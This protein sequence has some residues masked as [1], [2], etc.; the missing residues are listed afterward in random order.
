MKQDIHPEY[1][2]IKVEMTDGTV[3]E[4]RSTWGE[5]GQTLKLDVDPKTHPAWT[6][7]ERQVLDAGQ[8]SKFN[9]RY[10]DLGI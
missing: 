6:G 5:E 9:K 10:G 1:H 3:F 7:G 4:T 8:V 2:M